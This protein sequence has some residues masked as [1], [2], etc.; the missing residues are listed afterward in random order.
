MVRL[1][2]RTTALVLID[3]QNGVLGLPL[4]PRS[5]ADVVQAG[6][7]LAERFR[8]AGALVVLV[9]VACSDD[10]G[11]LLRQPVDK[12]RPQPPG[13]Y[14]DGWS[15][16]VDGLARPGDLVVAK[17]QWGAIYGTDLDLQLRRRAI[18]T[19]VLGGVATNMGVESTARQA[20]EH[21]YE[22]VIA[23]DATTSR[24]AE[25]HGF[26]INVILPMISR[27]TTVSRARDAE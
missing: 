27:V 21:A 16:L 8:Q 10:G 9:Q 3:L 19:V 20:W 17:R 11:D 12:P 7:V 23:E 4:G 14:P 2:P 18:R 6:R 26:A 5:G 22:V 24:T 1:N 13:G 25:M 15:N